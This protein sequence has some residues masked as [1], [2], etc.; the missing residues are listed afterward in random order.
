MKFL[1]Y[2]NFIVAISLSINMILLSDLSSKIKNLQE[3]IVIN[4]KFYK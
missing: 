4:N 3:K 2:V 1:L